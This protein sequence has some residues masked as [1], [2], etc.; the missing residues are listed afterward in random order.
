MRVT[1]LS[2]P[3]ERLEAGLRSSLRLC[4]FLPFCPSLPRLAAIAKHGGLLMRLIRRHATTLGPSLLDPEAA[5]LR[6]RI[7]AQ[8]ATLRLALGPRPRSQ[9]H[10]KE[11]TFVANYSA[12]DPLLANL[13]REANLQ[14]RTLNCHVKEGRDAA[15]RLRKAGDAAA[16]QK[17][18][19]SG[20]MALAMADA[21]IAKGPAAAALAQLGLAPPSTATR[22]A[23]A[24][25]EVHPRNFLSPPF[26]ATHVIPVGR[27]HG[28]VPPRHVAS[29]SSAAAGLGEEAHEVRDDLDADGSEIRG[30]TAPLLGI[31]GDHGRAPSTVLTDA[32]SGLHDSVDARSGAVGLGNSGLLDIGSAVT[33]PSE[34][35]HADVLEDFGH[36]TLHPRAASSLMRL[37]VEAGS[38]VPLSAGSSMSIAW[39]GGNGS[40]DPRAGRGAGMGSGACLDPCLSSLSETVA[41]APTASGET[42]SSKILSE[43]PPE[44]ICDDNAATRAVDLSS[45]VGSAVAGMP[46]QQLSSRPAQNTAKVPRSR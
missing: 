10:V 28:V 21:E 24:W 1:M 15:V 25:P 16:A 41:L 12:L 20:E 44:T 39:V 30:S 6:Q 19:L 13:V 11:D 17:S 42:A 5:K 31:L 18:I 32:P 40:I 22:T 7:A 35:S 33:S 38:F 8:S 43:D 4:P 27:Q 14:I 2:K 45:A 36:A 34:V 26:T 37:P 23:G 29:S 3:H 46:E 9:L